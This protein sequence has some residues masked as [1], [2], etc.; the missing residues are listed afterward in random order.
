[1]TGRLDEIWSVSGNSEKKEDI[2]AFNNLPQT[3]MDDA[4]TF[5]KTDWK[6]P[7]PDTL[8]T[9]DVAKLLATKIL[10]VVP[11]AQY[12]LEEVEQIDKLKLPIS[13]SL[14]TSAQN[15]QQRSIFYKHWN[16]LGR[17]YPANAN[18]LTQWQLELQ[19][20]QDS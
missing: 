5:W 8:A 9:V 4:M 16:E 17:P 2:E 11:Q 10:N 7:D 12:F 18:D 6:E 13:L 19:K 3:L 15:Q 14:Q 1:L 20:H